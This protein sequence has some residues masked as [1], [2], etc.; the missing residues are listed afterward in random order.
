MCCG[1]DLAGAGSVGGAGDVTVAVEVDGPAGS[2]K[3]V[4]WLLA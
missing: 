1:N 2:W 3:L 4:P